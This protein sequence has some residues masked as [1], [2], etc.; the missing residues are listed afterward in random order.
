MPER[1]EPQPLT[2]MSLA[3]TFQ[4]GYTQKSA[5]KKR[6]DAIFVN[7]CMFV[8]FDETRNSRPTKSDKII[9]CANP[10]SGKTCKL[11][12]PRAGLREQMGR[13][14]PKNEHRR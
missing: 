4:Q 2:P 3:A 12:W 13:L 6:P 10:P 8:K 7:Y 1:T 11:T 5:K 14:P 9:F